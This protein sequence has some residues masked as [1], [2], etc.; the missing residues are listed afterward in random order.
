MLP[1]LHLP[2]EDENSAH[3]WR[4]VF[5][6]RFA[7]TNDLAFQEAWNIANKYIED[8]FDVDDMWG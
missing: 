2:I 6:E 3:F 1:D 7:A 8:T 5:A 4:D